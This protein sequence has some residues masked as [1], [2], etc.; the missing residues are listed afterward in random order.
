ME[1][2]LDKRSVISFFRSPAQAGLKLKCVLTLACQSLH[3]DPLARMTA[4]KMEQ[5]LRIIA[6]AGQQEMGELF[7]VLTEQ[8]TLAGFQEVD[9]SDYQEEFNLSNPGALRFK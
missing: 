2:L 9:I 4:A 3:M 7:Q 1:M 6:R 8:G 5:Q